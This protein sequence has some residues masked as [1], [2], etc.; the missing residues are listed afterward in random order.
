MV[1]DDDNIN[2]DDNNNNNNVRKAKEKDKKK[3][4][5][6]G[7]RKGREAKGIKRE[8]RTSVREKESRQA[9]APC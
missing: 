6:G 2:D 8:K 3:E 9:H 4:V 7:G 5:R 1:K